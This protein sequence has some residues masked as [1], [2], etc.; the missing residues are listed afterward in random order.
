LGFGFGGLGF[1]DWAKSP[2]PNT[3]SPIPNPHLI[4][5]NNFIKINYCEK[6]N[7]KNLF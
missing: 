6:N 5:K 7:K 4:L 2:I 3:Q 1:G